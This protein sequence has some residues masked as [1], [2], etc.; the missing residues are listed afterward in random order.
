MLHNFKRIVDP[1][2]AKLLLEEKPG[3]SAG[4]KDL[5]TEGKSRQQLSWNALNQEKLISIFTSC[6]QQFS[7]QRLE[8]QLHADREMQNAVDEVCRKNKTTAAAEPENA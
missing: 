3:C 1:C 4:S 8:M 7:L 6:M 5:Y 2:T